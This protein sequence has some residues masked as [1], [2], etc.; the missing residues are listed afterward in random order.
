MHGLKGRLMATYMVVHGGYFFFFL[1]EWKMN[2]EVT[3]DSN[4]HEK[5]VNKNQEVVKDSNRRRG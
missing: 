2:Q 5:Y 3:K 4:S 1:L